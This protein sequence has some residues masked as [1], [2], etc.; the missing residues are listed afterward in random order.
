MRSSLFLSRL[1]SFLSSLAAAGATGRQA[2]P[3]LLAAAAR[4]AGGRA[5]DLVYPG[6]C[7]ECGAGAGG[8]EPFCPPCA[9]KVRW[10]TGA[11][12]RCGHPAP[13]PGP[14]PCGECAGRTLFFDR[15]AAAAEYTGPWRTAVLRFKYTGDQGLREVLV[16]AL[17]DTMG[18]L[19]PNGPPAAIVPV[20]AHPWRKLLRGR[21]PVEELAAA[22][23]LRKRIPLRLLLQRVRWIPSQTSLPRSRRLRNPRGAYRLRWLYRRQGRGPR[24]GPPC[25][26]ASVLLVDD[27]LTTCAT[28][29]EC[30]RVLKRAGV[31]EIGVAA[32]A[33]SPAI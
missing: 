10:I 28:A 2:L 3:R 31:G 22:L 21:D 14:G 23:A 33:R 18:R 1:L 32:L 24:P 20:P 6:F 30:A 7:R 11:C 8:S 26:S 16:A 19:F 12:S 4:R 17:E 15:A 13:N 25:L 29:A 9:A 5:L 27:V